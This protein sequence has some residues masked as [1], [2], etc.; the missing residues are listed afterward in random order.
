MRT[1][2]LSSRR[3]VPASW[4]DSARKRAIIAFVG[5]VA[6]EGAMRFVPP[7]ERIATFGN[8]SKKSTRFDGG[9]GA[10]RE[11]GQGEVAG[12]GDDA[13]VGR[14]PGADGVIRIQGLGV[15]RPRRGQGQPQEAL[16]GENS[17]R[18]AGIGCLLRQRGNDM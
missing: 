13:C 14:G 10:S 8:S 6:Q 15:R 3:P 4:N 2:G 18:R 11:G 9:L 16:A 17:I 1:D 5:A 7:A 12:G